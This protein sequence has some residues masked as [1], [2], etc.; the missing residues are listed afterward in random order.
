MDWVV[1]STDLNSIELLR[2]ELDQMTKLPINP[3]QIVG[4]AS[5]STE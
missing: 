3:V 1:Q 2:Y 5:V 4:G